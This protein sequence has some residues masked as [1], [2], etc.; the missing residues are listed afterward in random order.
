MQEDE[1]GK[2]NEGTIR[3]NKVGHEEEQ[4]EKGVTEKETAKK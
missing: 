1:E 4:Y 3:R 2:L